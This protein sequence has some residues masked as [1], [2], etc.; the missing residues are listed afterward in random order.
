[1]PK[2]VGITAAQIK[3]ARALIGFS[4]ADLAKAAGVG[5]TTIARLELGSQSPLAATL[6]AVFV[7]LSLS[8]VRFIDDGEPGSAGQPE[9]RGV[10]LRQ[11]G[12]GPLDDRALKQFKVLMEVRSDRPPD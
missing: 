3:A 1:M 4:Q 11:P 6:N 9:G 8:G 12:D 7:A 10:R 5:P 2:I